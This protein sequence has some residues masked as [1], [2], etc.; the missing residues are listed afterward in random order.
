MSIQNISQ[1]IIKNL[2]LR[3]RVISCLDINKNIRYPFAIFPKINSLRLIDKIESKLLKDIFRNKELKDFLCVN[4]QDIGQELYEK[5]KKFVES[6]NYDDSIF[7]FRNFG[8]VNDDSIKNNDEE[9]Y[10]YLKD[11]TNCFGSRIDFLG[12]KKIL[13][14]SKDKIRGFENNLLNPFVHLLN[15]ININPKVSNKECFE[16]DTS[17]SNIQNL[18]MAWQN[19]TIFERIIAKIIENK[20][21]CK[22]Y[23]SKYIVINQKN[24]LEYSLEFDNIFVWNNRICFIELKN[25]LIRRN[26]VFQFLGKVRAVENYYGFKIN[27]I[28]VIGTRVKEEIFSELEEKMPNFKV[29]DV[30]DYQNDFENFFE[31]IQ[32]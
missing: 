10:N 7:M 25:G 29:F 8:F 12:N 4:I 18:I 32:N 2:Q 23:C 13:N 14:L 6:K 11:L 27:K 3:N 26:E 5:H 20:L 16:I 24:P 21:K 30:E 17:N 19:K 15:S 1:T 31:F 9:Y 22:V 28:A